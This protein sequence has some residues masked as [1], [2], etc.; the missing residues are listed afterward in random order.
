MA[1]VFI[2]TV[3]D[4]P[5]RQRFRITVE[6]GYDIG[7][8]LP[9]ID[10]EPCRVTLQQFY[11]DN[12][13]YLWGETEKSGGAQ[14]AWERMSE[15]DLI[16]GYRENAIISVSHVLSKMDAPT[17]ADQTWGEYDGTSFRFIFFMT[18]PYLCNIRIVPQMFKYLDPTYDGLTKLGS[19]K[20]KNILAHYISLDDF[21]RL[22]FG[23]D[24]PSS[25][26]HS[27]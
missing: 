16:L 4:T 27:L 11:T 19:E 22:V 7:Q 2:F 23:Q 3:N 13:C 5:A 14:S 25:F 15:G 18:R 9:F 21:V 8:I 20:L 17:L 12:T 6:Y 10:D 1:N 24:F 26:R